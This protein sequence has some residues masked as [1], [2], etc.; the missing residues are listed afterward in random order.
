MPN[1]ATKAGSINLAKHYLNQDL[2]LA[3]GGS[4]LVWT[5]DSQPPYPSEN[6]N[7][8]SDLRGLLYLHIKRIVFKDDLGNIIT[9][10]S[11]YSYANPTLTTQ[12]LLDTNAFYLY[13]EAT[14]PINSALVGET[15]RFLGIAENAVLSVSPNLS[16]GT[17]VDAA[18]IISYDLAWINTVSSFTVLNSEQTFQFVRRW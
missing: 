12:Q 9:Q 10:D 8:F 5:N 7:N 18:D 14:L 4:S 15:F 3:F 1:V 6:I 13:L 16:K 11:R 2:W 17:F